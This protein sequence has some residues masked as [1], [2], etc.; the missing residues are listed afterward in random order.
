MSALNSDKKRVKAVIFDIDGTLTK[1]I[2]WRVLSRELGV[3]IDEHLNIFH[4]RM[5]G[6]ISE[7]EAKKR[8]LDLWRLSGKA[9]KDIIE[10]IFD[11][12]E[13]RKEAGEIINYLK[14]KKYKICLI[15]GSVDK[16]AAIVA[17]KLGVKFYFF[18]TKFIYNQDGQL[19]DYDYE[20]AQGKK[21]LEQLKQ[22]SR[23]QGIELKE[24]AVVGDSFNDYEL[25]KET[26][27]GIAVKTEFE[28]KELE[29]VAW[30][31]IKNLNELKQWF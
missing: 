21:K 1:E 25:F 10:K 26:G 23:E 2:S 13:L 8:F 29:K 19:V 31:I 12:I 11:G 20:E 7:S 15:T 6:E 3:S 24:C 14:S 30:K 4:A 28:E 9:H 18:N 22:F 17:E 16:H 5:R 27:R